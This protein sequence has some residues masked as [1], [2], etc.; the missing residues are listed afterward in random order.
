MGGKRKTKK[1]AAKRFKR[2]ATGKIQ[3][4]HAGRGHLFS[5]KSRKQKRQRRAGVLVSKA[6]HARISRL[7]PS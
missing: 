3:R 2:T 7:L 6:D 4:S 5:G 1:A